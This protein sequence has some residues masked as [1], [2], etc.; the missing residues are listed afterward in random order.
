LGWYDVV[1]DSNRSDGNWVLNL[2]IQ[3]REGRDDHV[4]L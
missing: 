3:N 2:M 1:G 4:I